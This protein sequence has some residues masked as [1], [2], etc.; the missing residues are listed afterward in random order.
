MDGKGKL[1]WAKPG[2]QVQPEPGEEGEE[3]GSVTCKYVKYGPHSKE[4]ALEPNQRAKQC[5]PG[6][7]YFHYIHHAQFLSVADSQKGD[8]G[9]DL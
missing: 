5:P 3:G 9:R 8:Q 2:L 1:C 4:E 7:F 6:E